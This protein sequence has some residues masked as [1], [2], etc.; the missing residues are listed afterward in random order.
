MCWSYFLFHGELNDFFSKDKPQGY[1]PYKVNRRAA[2]KDVIESL[3]PPHTEID[4]IL[5]NGQA[6]GFDYHLQPEDQVQ[7]FPFNAPVNTERATLLHPRIFPLGK[8]IVDV[9]VGKLAN[10]LRLLGL[11]AAYNPDWEDKY[12]AQKSLAEKRTVLT[13]DL[14][15]LK[16]NDVIWGRYVRAN[17]PAEQIKEIVY[18][19]G[20][21]ERLEPFSRCLRC[22]IRLAPVSK[23]EILHRL[24]P[25]TKKYF[26]DFS[27]CPK[28]QR[29]YWAGSHHEHM[30]N[31]LE[32]IKSFTQEN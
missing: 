19:F 4:Y 5:V 7:V 30:Q 14:G 32:L 21:Q 13:K 27:I 17:L 31:W 2:I 24:E 16:R 1:L 11:N 6:Q 22:N 12:I 25:K 26:N 15:L 20:L 18:F 3:G 8:F 10:L 29:I 23:Q 9:N 28:C